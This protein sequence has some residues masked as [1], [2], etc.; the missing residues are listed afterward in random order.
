[1]R[2]WVTS[3]EEVIDNKLKKWRKVPKV[4]NG[5]AVQLAWQWEQVRLSINIFWEDQKEMVVLSYCSPRTDHTYRW[6]GLSDGTF[7]NV[8]D[9]TG[10]LAQTAMYPTI[11][12][13]E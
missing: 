13:L 10:N 4:E 11:N 8:M 2:D 3:I 6:H 12:A 1:M 9:R 7:N 5:E